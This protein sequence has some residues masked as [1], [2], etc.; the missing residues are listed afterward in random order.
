MRILTVDVGG[1]NVK[2]LATGQE[3]PRKVASGRKM[4]AKRMVAAVQRLANAWEY[5]VV[6]LGYP[7]PVHKGRPAEEPRNLARGWVDFD[8]E[9]AFGRP[10]KVINDA[11]MQALGSYTRGKML[12]LGLGTGLGSC[13]VARR[14]AVPLELGLLHYKKG[15]YEDYL[16]RRALRRRGPAKW[17]KDV[18]EIVS[19]LRR[20]LRLDEIVLGGG[21]AKKLIR[22]PK[23][24]RLGSNAD[25]FLGGYR[26]WEAPKRRSQARDRAGGRS[27]RPSERRRR[28][29]ASGAS[30]HV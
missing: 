25:A 9:K 8:F 3:L 21:N 16:G 5:D 1:T 18:E 2:I 4:T 28:P 7:G 24:C 22:I 13:V 19:H 12:F 23:G 10:V 20:V 6:S 15:S 26:M 11:A 29:S 30:S 17:T 27:A 14:R